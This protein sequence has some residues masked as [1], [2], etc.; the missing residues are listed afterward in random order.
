MNPQSWL[1]KRIWSQQDS[2]N[3]IMIWSEHTKQLPPINWAVFLR[4]HL[5]Y[6]KCSRIDLIINCVALNAINIVESRWQTIEF[7]RKFTCVIKKMEK[8]QK[9]DRIKNLKFRIEHLDCFLL[10]L[11]LIGIWIRVTEKGIYPN[12]SELSIYLSIYIPLKFK[13]KIL[14]P[15]C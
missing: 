13:L 10:N 2:F 4:E 14:H 6:S 7:Q 15:V 1:F 12:L 8:S 11:N 9:C 5:F 3:N